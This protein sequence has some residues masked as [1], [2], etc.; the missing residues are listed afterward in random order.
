MQEVG[1][2]VAQARNRAVPVS[3]SWSWELARVP[4]AVKPDFQCVLTHWNQGFMAFSGRGTP[5]T[6]MLK[7]P[8]WPAS[9]FAGHGV[10]GRSH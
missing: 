1:V 3:L 5:R 2:G 6:G 4:D 9:D 7:V 8:V 10:P